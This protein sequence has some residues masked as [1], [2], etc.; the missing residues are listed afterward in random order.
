MNRYVKS[1]PAKFLDCSP[2]RVEARGQG[3]DL[4]HGAG[5]ALVPRTLPTSREMIENNDLKKRSGGEDTTTSKKKS[6]VHSENN[7]ISP[8]ARGQYGISKV[9]HLNVG[10]DLEG[11]LGGRCFRETRTFPC[12]TSGRGGGGSGRQLKDPG[13]G[14][15]SLDGQRALKVLQNNDITS[16]PLKTVEPN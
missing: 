2:R 8:L 1:V 10:S 5:D 15:L 3:D 16:T 14:A 11:A 13:T 7:K 9:P 4:D 12:M 6:L